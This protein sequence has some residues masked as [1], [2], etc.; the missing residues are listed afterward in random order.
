MSD[1]Q[2]NEQT[3]PDL[4]YVYQELTKND[5]GKY[6]LVSMIA[7]IL[8]KESKIEFY[9]SKNGKPTAEDLRVFRDL[10]MLSTT[11]SGYRSNA[12]KIVQD[13]LAN[14][15][16]DKIIQIEAKYEATTEAEMTGSLDNLST[17]VNAKHVVMDG[18]VS[19]LRQ[20]VESNQQLLESKIDKFVNRGFWG[21]V[22]EIG[23]GAIITFLSTVIL[24]FIL[25][26]VKGKE[27]QGHIE[28]AT[29]PTVVQPNSQVQQPTSSP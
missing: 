2:I 14:A 20:L 28:Q 27:L 10:N 3:N 1:E 24:W 12:E 18:K 23:R 15:W 21:W 19:S 16:G 5:N 17:N 6:I 29:M 22:L 9:K 26:S 11:L 7:Y 4:S 13:L 8:Y 25:V